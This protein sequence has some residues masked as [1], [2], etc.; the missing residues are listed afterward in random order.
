MNKKT[1]QQSTIIGIN[2]S[3][4]ETIKDLIFG[5]NIEAY[6]SEFEA[7]KK[8]LIKK[9]TALEHLIDTTQA[10]LNEVIDNLSTNLNIRITD[11]EDHLE[12][13]FKTLNEEKMDRKQ[14]GNM[15]IK[16][17]NKISE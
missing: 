5:E 9:K 4:I 10:H 17:G 3:K 6:E 1:E 13:K 7:I 14:L 8:D 15:L 11:L 2:K 12:D 16:L